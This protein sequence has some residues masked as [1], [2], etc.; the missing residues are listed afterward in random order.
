MDDLEY[1]RLYE[2]FRKEVNFLEFWMINNLLNN[3]EPKIIFNEEQAN[4]LTE[5]F[6]KS[7][8]NLFDKE[9]IITVIKKLVKNDTK[10]C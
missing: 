3:A 2:I 6:N 5:L 1:Y 7:N 9:C 8:K 4:K 10:S